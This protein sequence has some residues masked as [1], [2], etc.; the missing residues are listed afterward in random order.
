M[1]QQIHPV[2]VAGWPSNFAVEIKPKLKDFS[3]K[4]LKINKFTGASWFFTGGLSKSYVWNIL[5]YHKK[6]CYFDQNPK[7]KGNISLS[8]FDG[9]LQVV[10]FTC[11]CLC[12]RIF[13]LVAVA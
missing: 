6:C 13:R 5:R 8:N 4:R 12:V 7:C 11:L 3:G 10:L 9:Q 1:E 2:Q